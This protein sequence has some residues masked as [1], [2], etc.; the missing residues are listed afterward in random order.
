LILN[1][2]LGIPIEKLRR[3][4]DAIQSERSEISGQLADAT[5]RL[6]TGCQFFLAALELRRDPRAFYEEGGTSLKAGDKRGH[7]HQAVRRRRGDHRC[8]SPVTVGM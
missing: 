8:P 4:L 3:K 1:F 7:L 5:T 6:A 2:S